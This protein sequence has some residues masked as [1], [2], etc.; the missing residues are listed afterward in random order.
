MEI[1]KQ[2]KRQRERAKEKHHDNIEVKSIEL[3]NETQ[4]I[5]GRGE[6]KEKVRTIY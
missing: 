1:K 2:R 5:F 3:S 6:K 4:K